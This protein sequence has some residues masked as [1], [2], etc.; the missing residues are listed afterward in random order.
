MTR[1]YLYRHVTVIRLN[2]LLPKLPR[3]FSLGSLFPSEG[4]NSADAD[5]RI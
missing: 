1:Q 4:L 5:D 2:D 3:R